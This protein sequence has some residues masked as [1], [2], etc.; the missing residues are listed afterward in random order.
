MST[1]SEQVNQKVVSKSQK[2]SPTTD[3]LGSKDPL[4]E[5]ATYQSSSTLQTIVVRYDCKH[6]LQSLMHGWPLTEDLVM[7]CSWT[8]PPCALDMHLQ[9]AKTV[10]KENYRR[11]DASVHLD[12]ALQLPHDGMIHEARDDGTKAYLSRLWTEKERSGSLKDHEKHASTGLLIQSACCNEFTWARFIEVDYI[13]GTYRN[14]KIPSRRIDLKQRVTKWNCFLVFQ[15]FIREERW[16]SSG[17]H[18]L[19]GWIV[20]FLEQGFF[21]RV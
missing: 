13:C 6:H 16:L 19:S 17:Q 3:R 2:L 14:R 8:Q 20:L 1:S 5:P 9:Q 10:L 12:W 4:P 21:D 18:V 7:S 15:H 11:K